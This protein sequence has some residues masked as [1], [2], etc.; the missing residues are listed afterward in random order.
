LRYAFRERSE[1]HRLGSRPGEKRF[2]GLS[3]D[4]QVLGFDPGC[5]GYSRVSVPPEEPLGG[6][7]QHRCEIGDSLTSLLNDITVVS[8]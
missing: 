1:K 7:Q 4:A 5:L 3:F 8:D 6:I 2:H